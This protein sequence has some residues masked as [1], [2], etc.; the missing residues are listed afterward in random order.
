MMT[1]QSQ[2]GTRPEVSFWS[3]HHIHWLPGQLMGPSH[4]YRPQIV[5]PPLLSP[6]SFCLLA[7]IHPFTFVRGLIP[8]FPSA[9]LDI[10]LSCLELKGFPVTPLQEVGPTREDDRTEVLLGKVPSLPAKWSLFI[11]SLS[12][13]AFSLIFLLSGLVP[14][15]S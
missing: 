10:H 11:V 5:A 8:L 7:L 2:M 9:S 14:F 15:A 4:S 3:T 1:F 6:H 13:L 12:F